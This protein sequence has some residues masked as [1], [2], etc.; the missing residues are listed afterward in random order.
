MGAVEMDRHNVTGAQPCGDHT[1]LPPGRGVKESLLAEAARWF[2]DTFPEAT[3]Y[4]TAH[5]HATWTVMA[6][7][8]IRTRDHFLLACKWAIMTIW[9]DTALLQHRESTLAADALRGRPLPPDAG[10]L[11]VNLVALLTEFGDIC[12]VQENY[13]QYLKYMSGY[14]ALLGKP[15]SEHADFYTRRVYDVGLLPFYILTADSHGRRFEAPENFI[16]HAVFSTEVDNRVTSFT[17]ELFE[18]PET[19]RSPLVENCTD[20]AV[21][22]QVDAMFDDYVAQLATLDF[23]FY[24]V[25]ALQGRIGSLLWSLRSKRYGLLLKTALSEETRTQLVRNLEKHVVQRNGY[26]GYA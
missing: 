17:K 10:P 26:Y 9:S 11:C 5:D 14:F 15:G 1:D 19:D 4:E 13:H 24:S 20:A 18:P 22:Q 25:I 3:T 2:C 8:Y 21:N 6:M 12:R 7:P 23:D 16:D